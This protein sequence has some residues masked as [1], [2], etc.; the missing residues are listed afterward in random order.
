MSREALWRKLHSLSPELAISQWHWVMGNPTISLPNADGQCELRY[1][2]AGVPV[3][4]PFFSLAFSLI[5]KLSC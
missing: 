3:G 5:L 1:L 4:N 2:G